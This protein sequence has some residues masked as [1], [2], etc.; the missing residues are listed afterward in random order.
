MIRFWNH[1]LADEV[2]AVLEL[3]DEFVASDDRWPVPEG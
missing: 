1:P 3:V 2:P